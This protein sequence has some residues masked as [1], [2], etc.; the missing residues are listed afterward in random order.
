MTTS[1]VIGSILFSRDDLF[2]VIQ[3]AVSSGSDL[4]AHSWFQINVY[5]PGYVFPSASLR[6]ECVERIVAT[7]DGFIG[8]HLSVGLDAVFQAVKLPTGISD[9]NTGLPNM[10]RYTFTHSFERL[11]V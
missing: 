9:L 4:I 3:L 5:S 6:K 8:G 2:R 1:V 11:K 10:D 7:T